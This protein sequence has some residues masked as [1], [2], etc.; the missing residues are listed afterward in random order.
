MAKVSRVICDMTGTEF[1][2]G[3]DGHEDVTF[4]WDGSKY[5]ID[6][7]DA[8]MEKLAKVFGPVIS[9]AR[10]APLSQAEHMQAVKAW[11]GRCKSWANKNGHGDKVPAKGKYPDELVK[12]YE[13]ANPADPKPVRETEDDE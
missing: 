4:V 5:E 2:P 1:T 3:T 12:I 7:S 8:G 9:K 6:L 11:N 10:K 13:T